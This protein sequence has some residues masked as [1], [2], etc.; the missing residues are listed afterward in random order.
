M[1]M[2]SMVEYR[3]VSHW[4]KRQCVW[5]LNDATQEAVQSH[6]NLTAISRCCDDPRCMR[7]SAEMCESTV[8]AA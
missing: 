7:L 3:P 8:G 4:Q 2:K 1:F 6:A 5:C